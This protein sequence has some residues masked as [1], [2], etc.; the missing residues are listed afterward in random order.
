MSGYLTETN[1]SPSSTRLAFAAIVVT[2]LS[3]FAY[4]M[5]TGKPIPTIPESVLVLLGI[6]MGGKVTQKAF[7]AKPDEA[8]G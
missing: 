2:V 7:E 1:G 3:A 8:K 4:A 6:G 5:V